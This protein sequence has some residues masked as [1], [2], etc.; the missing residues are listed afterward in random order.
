MSTAIRRSSQRGCI[1]AAG[2]R[3]RNNSRL[4]SASATHRL[5]SGVFARPCVRR[6]LT[7][8][9]HRPTETSSCGGGPAVNRLSIDR[10]TTVVSAGTRYNRGLTPNATYFSG[11]RS[12]PYALASGVLRENVSCRAPVASAIGSQNTTVGVKVDGIGREPSGVST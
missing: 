2:C 10:K 7:G 6:T 8:C 9:D 11:S 3:D 12:E 1:E 4:A 5:I